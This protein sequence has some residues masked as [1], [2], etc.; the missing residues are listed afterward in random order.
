MRFSSH[1]KNSPDYLGE[2]SSTPRRHQ[3]PTIVGSWCSLGIIIR[4]AT[5]SGDFYLLSLM[6]ARRDNQ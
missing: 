4:L 5:F 6:D 2:V 1:L 3:H